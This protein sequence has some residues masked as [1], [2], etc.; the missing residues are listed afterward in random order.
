[1]LKASRR[2]QLGSTPKFAVRNI[3]VQVFLAQTTER[4]HLAK[5]TAISCFSHRPVL[6]V[7][8]MRE[9]GSWLR[10]GRIY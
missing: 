4:E 9:K 6:H 7:E 8:V 5:G 2:E 10:W 3:L 1:M